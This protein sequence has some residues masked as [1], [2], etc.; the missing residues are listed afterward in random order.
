MSETIFIGTDTDGVRQE[1]RL[2]KANRHGLIAGATGTG[3][4]V[5]LQILTEGFSSHGVPV[6]AADV[7]GDLSG[8]SQAGS[9]SHKLHDKLIKRAEKIGLDNYGYTAF[10][11]IFWDLYG[12]KGHPVRTTISEMGPVLLSRLMGLTETQE[13]IM[14]IAFEYADDN[15]MLLLD[16]K[17]LNALL[18]HLA[19]NRAEVSRE[20]GN[21][22][23]QSVAAIRRDLLTLER[24]GAEE[25]FGEP[26]LELEDFMRIDADG[27]NGKKRGK[28]NILAADELIN[29]PTL[30]GTF[31]LW[32]LSELFEELPEVGNPDKPKMIFFF[33]E[34]HLLFDDA[35]KPLI[36]KIEQVARLIRSKGVG[37]YFVTQ[38]PMDIPDSVLG[39]LGN[40]IQH[41]L[42]AY[43][44]KEQRA[45]RAAASSFRENPAFDTEDVIT[46]LGV[47]EA[48]VSLLDE[49]GA[50]A[51]VGRTMI[52]PP[53]SRLGPATQ[54]ERKAV[55]NDSP[56]GAKYDTAIDRESAYETL[57]SRA[58]ARAKQEAAEAKRAEREKAK[59][60]APTRRR[61][62][63]KKDNVIVKELK[64]E[65]R[66]IMRRA[67]R[68]AVRG[69]LG[70]MM[71]R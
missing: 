54:A 40:R 71:R 46:D 38:N 61:T 37:V 60:K 4:T 70:G 64:R 34:A 59:T 47:G 53:S 41:A 43:T 6:F 10:P 39:Q 21:V 8:L 5:T 19:E 14:T 51:I 7:K 29:S 36:Q 58:E 11:T 44:P 65:G 18:N 66:L 30:Y 3:K 20:Y 55:Q 26:A 48:L 63:R 24:A 50:P 12:K 56:V 31:L 16:L 13:G 2:D 67:M 35:P 27:P 45:V 62:T 32:L 57:E 25:F 9:E 52:R 1:L 68:N 23:G 42:R 22:T 15:G 28:V 33:D 49:R 69:I 17:D